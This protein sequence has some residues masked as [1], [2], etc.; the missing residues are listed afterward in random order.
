MLSETFLWLCGCGSRRVWD[1]VRILSVWVC[2]CQALDK[3][4]L[5]F[6]LVLFGCTCLMYPSSQAH[7]D[8]M[9]WF[10]WHLLSFLLLWAPCQACV[11]QMA[12]LVRWRLLIYLDTFTLCS[13]QLA[14]LLYFPVLAH[15]NLHLH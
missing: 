4:W 11:C 3:A 14:Y 5:W 7:R 12:L 9:V 15:Y 10:G 8:G 2:M 6:R 13:P 1:A